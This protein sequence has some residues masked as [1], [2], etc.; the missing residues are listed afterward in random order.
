MRSTRLTQWFLPWLMTAG[1]FSLSAVQASDAFWPE[2]GLSGDVPT[3]AEV[4]GHEPGEKISSPAELVR[5]LKALAV[6]AP[7]RTRL[8]QYAESWE[9]R[10]LY[11][12][13]VGSKETISRLDA[14]KQGMQQLADP[15]NLREGEAAELIEQLPAVVWL[16]YGVHGNEIS[17]GDAALLLAYHLLAASDPTFD[18]IRENVLVIIDPAQNPD[19]RAR[20]VQHYQ[21]H[22]G[23][24]PA[25]SAIAAERRE[26]WPGGRTNHY[27]FDMNRDWFALTQ[28]ETKGRVASL[29]EYY[30]LVHADIHE[31]GTDST[32]YFPPPAEPFNPH[33]TGQQKE[34]FDALGKGMA[35]IFD[36]F[37]FDYFTREVFDALYPGY[38]DSW[39]TLHGSLGMT[40]EAASARGLV[41]ERTDGSFVTYR[42]G[43]HRHFLATIG[44]LTVAA[45]DRESLLRRFYEFRQTALDDSRIYGVNTALNDSSLVRGLASR[46]ERQGIEV[47]ETV[48]EIRVCGE[49][50]SAGSLVVRAGQPAGR[51]VRTLMDAESPMDEDFLSEQE[52]R[53]EKG[54]GVDLYDVLGWSL[55]ALSNLEM[56][57]CDARIREAG[58]AAWEMNLKVGGVPAAP[59]AYLVPWEGDASV[60]FLAGALRA[61]LAV[62]TSTLPFTQKGKGF[63]AGTLIVKRSDNDESLHT[64]VSQLAQQTQAEV[65]GTETSWTEAG[66]NFGSNNVRKIPKVKIALAWDEPTRSLSAGATRYW[67]ER[68]FSYPVTPV[69]T[70]HLKGEPLNDFHVV[71]LPDG[72][73]Y[74]RY[75]GK[76]GVDELESWLQRGGVLVGLGRANRF[77][78]KQGLLATARE[79]RAGS[80]QDESQDKGRPNG[81]ML[82][83]TQDY[84]AAIT[85]SAAEPSPLPGVILRAEV[86]SD[87]WLA[88]GLK[89]RLNFVVTGSDIYQPLKRDV[90]MNVVRFA[91]PAAIGA[92]GHVWEDARVQL[93]FKPVVMVS[94]HGN[95]H[96]IGITADPTFRGYI[97]GLSVLLG[98]AFLR[99]PAYTDY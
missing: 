5:Y 97:D 32:Y 36:R 47:F 29:L 74:E 46:L 67:L 12:L 91:D 95:G 64:T 38:G 50:L 57:S 81:S 94:P 10:P 11:Y 4:L 49:I 42:D 30:P 66:S 53:R 35:E 98:N 18:A 63:G 43:V 76:R 45:R 41:G 68:K 34:G 33:I 72:S 78:T 2:A 48:E 73:D 75:L 83:S 88:A 70:E 25:P 19:G 22:A 55:P 86:D 28:P 52:R 93:A 54:L 8:I 3:L 16:S 61:G 7:G 71:I 85:P 17:S 59:L 15:R 90:G 13:A 65:I 99:A 27:L 60:R 84:K 82:A 26:A 58:L 77:L 62:H 20:F 92:G 89:P 40:F 1:L 96:V 51:L 39:P 23:I 44:T 6:A 14:I 24:E 87:H 79:Y 69:R 80:D 37:G 31:M 21:Q 56:V 9:G